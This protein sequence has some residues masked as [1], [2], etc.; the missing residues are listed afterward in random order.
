MPCMLT[1]S[2]LRGLGIRHVAADHG[3]HGAGPLIL[4]RGLA[5]SSK[6]KPDAA[7]EEACTAGGFRSMGCVASAA[8]ELHALQTVM[9]LGKGLLG[10][11]CPLITCSVHPRKEWRQEDT[12]RQA[13]LA[14]WCACSASRVSPSIN[15]LNWQRKGLQSVLAEVQRALRFCRRQRT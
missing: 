11:R 12:K 5:H 3:G 7:T 6:F 14:T 2:C 8:C 10:S 4:S 15:R 9:A 1:V 13:L